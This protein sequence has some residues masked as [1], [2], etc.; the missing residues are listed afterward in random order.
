[1]KIKKVE[2]EQIYKMDVLVVGGGPAGIGAAIGGDEKRLL[3]DCTGDA[4]L[5]YRAGTPT[6]T[7]RES[8][9]KTRPMTL[10]FRMGNIEVNWVEHYPY[11]T[12]GYGWLSSIRLNWVAFE[13]ARFLENQ[14]HLT[15]PYPSF[16]QGKKAAISNRHSAVAA[17]I[18]S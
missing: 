5:A 2:M 12:F 9:H 3:I 7:G 14:G 18:E 11:Q 17:G 1:M 16:F 13:V 4:D 15:C 8:D 6:T 10:L